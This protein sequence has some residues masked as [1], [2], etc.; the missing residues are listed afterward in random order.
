MV[1]TSD[2]SKRIEE[3]RKKKLE[4]QKKLFD[5]ANRKNQKTPTLSSNKSIKKKDYI[6]YD[7]SSFNDSHGGFINEKL[8]TLENNTDAQ[9]S[10]EKKKTFQLP[11]PTNIETAPKCVE[12]NS[13]DIDM[14]YFKSF[15]NTKVCRNCIKS[16]P[17]K[18]SLLTKTESKNDYFLTDSELRDKNLF[19]R[20]EKD[21]PHG[22]AKMQLFLRSHIEEFAWKKWGSPDA[23]DEEWERRQAVKLKKRDL[24]YKKKLLQIRLRTRAEEY[25]KTLKKKK[26]LSSSHK[27]EWSDE[28]NYISEKV[29]KKRCVICG[30]EIEEFVVSF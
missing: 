24:L 18:Y 10:L 7:L 9:K 26:N 25:T 4:F 6:E 21:N 28:K 20:I 16:F 13:W 27:H 11:F 14:L 5:N 30:I 15:N 23:L 22:F 2:Q 29:F 1:L 3:N 17:E 19:P 12:C 8:T